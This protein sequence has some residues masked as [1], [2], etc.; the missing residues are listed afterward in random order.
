MGV[1]VYLNQTE[2]ITVTFYGFPDDEGESQPEDPTSLEVRIYDTATDPDVLILTDSAIPVGPV[3][4]FYYEWTPTVLGEFNVQFFATFADDSTNPVSN[5]FTVY[6]PSSTSV[7]GSTL[8]ADQVITL[9]GVLDPLY[10]DPVGVQT[11]YPDADLVQIA[12]LVNRYSTEVKTLLKL[13]DEDYPP[14]IALDYIEAATLCSLTRLFGEQAGSDFTFQLGDLSVT[15]RPIQKS[16][17]TRG[18]A[19]TWC[20]LAAAL[21]YDMLADQVGMKAVC[22]GKGGGD[23]RHLIPSRKLRAYRDSGGA[24]SIWEYVPDSRTYNGDPR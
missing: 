23:R 22:K 9:T 17:I 13:K 24:S 2:K 6:E 3:G 12:E 10:I 11:F 19:T 21:R 8:L 18:N 15:N 5:L 1:T 20:E 7:V 4:K 16:V 14:I